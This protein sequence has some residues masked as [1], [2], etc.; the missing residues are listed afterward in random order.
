MQC[1]ELYVVHMQGHYVLTLVL[2]VPLAIICQYQTLHREVL[3]P[4]FI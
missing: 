2:M 4:S 1:A 3:S